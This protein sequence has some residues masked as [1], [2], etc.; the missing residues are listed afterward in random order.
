MADEDD[1]QRLCARLDWCTDPRFV[2]GSAGGIVRAPALTPRAFCD[3]DLA[4]I[5]RKLREMPRQYLWLK[6]ELGRPSG[7]GHAIRVPFG[8]RVPLRVDVD[9]LMCLIR[10]CL[11]CWHGHVAEAAHLTFPDDLAP[12]LPEDAELA[13][14]VIPWSRL[15][16]DAIAVREDADVL[17][18]HLTTLAGLETVPVTRAVDLLD[19]LHGPD[20]TEGIVRAA[21]ATLH[22]EMDGAGAGLELLWLHYLA[23]AV[24]GETKARPVELEG[25]PCRGCGERSLVRAEPPSNPN[26]PGSWSE[27]LACNDRMTE[28]SYRDWVALCAA[29]ER[30]NRRAPGTLD[31]L[32]PVDVL[33]A[34]LAKQPNLQ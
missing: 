10:D 9:A 19:E 14:P 4:D 23:R 12:D 15:R 11:T 18:A 28:D 21:F 3:K 2:P 20:D 13:G 32:P 25:I 34:T 8:P 1:G 17:R 6:F 16:R 5:G 33:I 24:L 7:S 27:C 22:L 31:E 26:D 30:S 29:Y